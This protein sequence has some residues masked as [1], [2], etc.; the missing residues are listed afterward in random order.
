MPKITKVLT[1]LEVGRIKEPGVHLVGTVAGLALSV[2]PSGSGRSWLLR[3]MVHGKRREFG[4]GSFPEVTLA[5]AHQKAREMKDKL[6]QGVDPVQEKHEAARRLLATKFT[7]KTFTECC[8]AYVLAHGPTWRNAKHRQQWENTLASYA[9]P[10][11]GQLPIDAVDTAGVMAVLQPIWST[12]TET[13]TRLR[14]RIEQVLDWATVQKMRQGENPARWKGHLDKLLPKPSKVA[15]VEHHKALAYTDMGAF[16]P[17][18]LEVAGMGAQALRFTIYTAGRSGEIRGARWSE[19]DLDAGVWT[20]P[21]DRMKA[22]REHRVPLSSEALELLKSLPR[23]DGT[24]VVFWGASGRELSDMSL[25]AVLRRMGMD[26]T[27]HGFRSTFRVW[28]AERT[29]F[30]REIAES[31]LAHTNGDKVEAAYLRSDHFEK[32]RHLMDQWAKFCHTPVSSAQVVS[33]AE[34]RTA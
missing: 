5:M 18:L 10:I 13:A 24:D 23:L 29:V 14:G 16:M 2:S 32:R 26:V 20:V 12:K 1:A 15:Q 9:A 19:I 8:V 11:I 21:A 4:L 33:I 27:V 3:T 22:H 25:S 34:A 6:A 17:K 31:A 30:P 7:N 28:A